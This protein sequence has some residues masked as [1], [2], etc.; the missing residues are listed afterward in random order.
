[1]H[2]FYRILQITKT[3]LIHLWLSITSTYF[4][5]NVFYYYQGYGI[6]YILTLFVISVSI[7]SGYF[8]HYIQAYQDYFFENKYS[9]YIDNLE[10]VLNQWPTI[11]YNNGT[12]S[13]DTDKPI[14]IKNNTNNIVI[15]VDPENKL[16]PSNYSKIL[17]VLTKNK[18][19]FN[20]G[21]SNMISKD[22]VSIFH[23]NVVLDKKTLIEYI[24]IAL[25]N[26]DLVLIFIIT[27]IIICIRFIAFLIKKIFLALLIYVICIQFYKKIDI[28]QILRVL[29]FASGPY[30][31]FSGLTPFLKYA[32]F[33]TI[34]YFWA[35]LLLIIAIYN[36][37][38][39]ANILR[40]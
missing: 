31:L 1:M 27:P 8:A 21:K 5:Y 4:Y 26:A 6:K 37:K 35:N 40:H 30:V 15:I 11:Y 34:I 13:A 39:Y 19:I 18:L 12:I 14:F 23:T 10:C 3:Y 38:N 29:I 36:R 22:Y 2:M 32:L 16:L 20:Y 28:K 24:K 17:L 33:P 9:N 7:Y 25:S